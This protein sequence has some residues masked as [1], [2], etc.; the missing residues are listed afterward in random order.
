MIA[1]WLAA[2]SRIRIQGHTLSAVDDPAAD[3]LRVV[4][5][6]GDLHQLSHTALGHHG[7]PHVIGE[8]AETLA[9]LMVRGMTCI[10][11]AP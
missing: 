10:D 11:E 8:V 7:G 9:S 5:A 3:Q 1:L 6:T 4:A 2:V